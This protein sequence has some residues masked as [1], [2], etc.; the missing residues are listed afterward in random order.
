MSKSDH[1]EG[2]SSRQDK[3]ILP[4]AVEPM[5][6]YTRQQLQNNLNTSKDTFAKWIAAGLKPIPNTGTGTELFFADDVINYFRK[7]AHPG[8]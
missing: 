4:P 2:T 1:R 7:L 3:T 5:G 8:A 6:I